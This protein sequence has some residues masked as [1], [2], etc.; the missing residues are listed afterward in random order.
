MSIEWVRNQSVETVSSHSTHTIPEHPLDRGSVAYRPD[1]TDN[2]EGGGQHSKY[3]NH[4]GPSYYRSITGD[5]C[6]NP[7]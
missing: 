1:F 2:P 6:A 4:A 3:A 5:N 7:A